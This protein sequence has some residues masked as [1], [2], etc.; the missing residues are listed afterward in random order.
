MDAGVEG[1]GKTPGVRSRFSGLRRLRATLAL[2][3]SFMKACS[4]P[5]GSATGRLV[6]TCEV[7]VAWRAAQAALLV[8]AALT[9]CLGCSPAAAPTE[10]RPAHAPADS[11]SPSLSPAHKQE[12]SAVSQNLSDMPVPSATVPS[13][14]V[15]APRNLGDDATRGAPA[16]AW[17]VFRGDAQGSGVSRGTLP[18]R[19]D[20]LWKVTLPDGS[21]E[22]TAVID[23]G[24]VYAGCL[25]GNLLAL[26]L[27]TGEERWR[28]Y[29]ELGFLASAAVRDGRVYVG[30]T[31]GKFFCLEAASGSVVWS[32]ETKAEIDNGAN[33]YGDLVLVGSQDAT[34][35][36]LRA[37]SGELAWQY[38]IADQIRCMPTVV[39]DR[40][41]L[42]GCDGKLHVIDLT[43]GTSLSQIDIQAPTGCSPA[44]AGEMV[45]FGT[46]GE[47]V[48]GIAWAQAELVWAYRRQAR[49]FPFRSS[50][51][52]TAQMVVLGGR[53]KLVR[54]LDP[55]TGEERWTFAAKAR[56]DS[57]P[58][59]VGQRVFVGSS[60]GRLY[61]LDLATGA[62]R[63]E[64]EAGGSF[65]ASPAVAAGRLV[66]G[67]DDGVLFCFGQAP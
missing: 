49:N 39:D 35:Y 58:V 22:A 43:Q 29:S 15:A 66:I 37:A 6:P 53:D 65:L 44:V 10:N 42:A 17:P 60:D 55:Q 25:D 19:L 57:S 21:F 56:V 32:F 64:Y 45:Y 63:W 18:E 26:D 33:F 11:P 51:A 52:A 30:D 1:V 47:T 8:F 31:N 41:F 24:V 20:V 2:G 54:G 7:V 13:A 46:E 4:K 27:A 3:G 40:C 9:Q 12:S 48:F 14:K 5:V 28:F 67:N 50:A 16:D 23:Q 61:E 62:L 34:L 38:Q 59:V 36:A